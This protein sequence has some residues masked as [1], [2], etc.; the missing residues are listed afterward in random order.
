MGL[1]EILL[2]AIVGLLLFGPH[3]LKVWVQALRK[4]KTIE[5]EARDVRDL[6]EDKK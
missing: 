1:T 2:I 5:L 4:T 3:P 6:G